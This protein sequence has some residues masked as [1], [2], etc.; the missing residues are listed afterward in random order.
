MISSLANPKIKSVRA[1]TRRR[2]RYREGRFVVEGLRLLDEVVRARLQ[3][4]WVLFTEGAAAD[5]RAADL[6]DAL[7]GRQVPCYPVSD[8]VMAA[9]SDT[10]TPAGLLA[11]LPF[12]R[13]SA[14]A[15][16][17]LVLVC[18]GMR[19]PG[20][21]GAVLR[22]AAAAGVEQVG[23]TSNTVDP[24]NPKT[25]RAGAGAHFRLPVAALSWE[26]LRA[27][28]AGLDV[29]LAAAGGNRPYHQV[30]WTRPVALVIGG[31][32]EGTDARMR[33]LATGCVSIPME[34]EIESLNAAVAAGI[35][36]FEIVR[37]R[38]AQ[39]GLG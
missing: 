24:Y 20:N 1:L 5:P 16:P 4:D 14:P 25:V 18:D 36:L 23:L 30:D 3:P 9:C 29:W 37:Q 7:R 26:Q 38:R 19:N 11:V 21:L 17:T 27:S 22:T 6:L 34:R 8:K 32:A 33:G 28:L 35:I 12:I 13:L 31:E 15:R 39:A 2:T 10:E